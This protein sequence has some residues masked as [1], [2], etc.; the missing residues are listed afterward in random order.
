MCSRVLFALFDD[1]EGPN[2][3]IVVGMA[4]LLYAV[5]VV[6]YMRIPQV[7]GTRRVLLAI[8]TQVLVVVVSY[9]A[10]R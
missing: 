1:P 8:L 7:M 4:L 9:L 10:L 2:V 6:T 5:S 3:L